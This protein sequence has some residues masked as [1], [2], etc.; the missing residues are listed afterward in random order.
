MER[1]VFT[2]LV[3]WLPDCRC[4]SQRSTGV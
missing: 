3:G 4:S 2:E 1:R